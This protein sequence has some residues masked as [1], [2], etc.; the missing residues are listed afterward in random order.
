M[1]GWSAQRSNYFTLCTICNVQ[2][3]QYIY[4]AAKKLKTMCY[5]YVAEK[6]VMVFTHAWC[7]NCKS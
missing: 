2:Y 6:W 1:I 4:Q 7:P 3:I 5:F